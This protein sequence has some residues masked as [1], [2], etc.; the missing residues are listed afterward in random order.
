MQGRHA[1]RQGGVGWWGGEEFNKRRWQ[2]QM[3]GEAMHERPGRQWGS[4]PGTT[5]CLHHCLPHLHIAS[6]PMSSCPVVNSQKSISYRDKENRHTLEMSELSKVNYHHPYPCLFSSCLSPQNY[7][8]HR[9]HYHTFSSLILH[10]RHTH[11][12]INNRRIE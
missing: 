7:H 3:R 9:Y 6:L 10:I 11:T 8:I 12:T 2:E 4:L 5:A 1:A